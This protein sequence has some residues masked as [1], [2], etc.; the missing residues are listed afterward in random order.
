M[1]EYIEYN[2]ISYCFSEKTVSLL[3]KGV[4]DMKRGTSRM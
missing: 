1:S 3:G 4:T 2:E